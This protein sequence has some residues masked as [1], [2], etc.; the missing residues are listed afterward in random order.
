MYVTGLKNYWKLSRNLHKPLSQLQERQWDDFCA[1][2]RFAYEKV[3][4]YRRLYHQA[5]FSPSDLKSPE[6]V[7]LIPTIH[8]K[9]LQEADPNGL[10]ASGFQRQKLVHKHTSGSSGAPFDV[11]YTAE[12][13]IYRT[14]LHLRIL[15]H[16]GMGFFDRMLQISDARNVPKFRYGFQKLRILPKDFLFCGDPPK[17]QLDLIA[18]TKPEVIYSY[19][20]NMVLL[21]AEVR[22]LGKLPHQPRLIFTTG[23]LMT[24]D[25]RKVINEAFKTQIRDIYGIV[26]MGDVAWQCPVVSGYHL[27]IDSFFVE[28]E[29]NGQAAQPGQTGRLIITNLHSRAMPFIRYEVGDVL[30]APREDP[31]SCGCTFPRID[32]IAGR[33]D[34]WLYSADGKR[35]SSMIFIIASVP[36]VAQYR[37]IQRALNYL[38]VEVMPGHNYNR[39]TLE[40]VK[41]HVQELMGEGTMVDVHKVDHIPRQA[42]KIRSVISEIGK[43]S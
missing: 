12:D 25:H 5:H 9:L 33:E 7:R 18:K 41:H 3:P 35:V 31:C 1:L 43:Q 16:N 39:E 30:T 36:G 4:F 15:F 37:I 2:V 17:Q 29:S 28:I 10:I 21:A 8:K 27:N 19:A 26:E 20:S 6:D 11:Y 23:E 32:V 14:L 38:I 24:P 22:Q 42:G 40:R 34:D 13:R